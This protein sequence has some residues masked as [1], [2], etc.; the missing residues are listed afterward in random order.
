[1]NPVFILLA[2]Y[3]LVLLESGLEKNISVILNTKHKKS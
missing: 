1:M 2:S 3:I